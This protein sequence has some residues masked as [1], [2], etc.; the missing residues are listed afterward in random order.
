MDWI[1]FFTAAL[2][3]GIVV[4]F[5]DFL[6]SEFTSKRN[7]TA[8]AKNIVN[9]HIDPIL[10]SADQLLGHLISLSDKDF[11]TL[12][13]KN[14][15]ESQ[16]E[17]EYSIY[18]FSHFWACLLIL[19]KD[20]VHVDLTKRKEGRHLLRFVSTL[21][22][23]RNRLLSRVEQQVIGEAL[24]QE[25]SRGL[26]IKSF[27]HFLEEYNDKNTSFNTWFSPLESQL[28]HSRNRRIRQDILLYGVILHAMVDNL[29]AGHQY[30]RDR[31]SYP[32]KLSKKTRND[33]KNRIFG[34][35]LTGIKNHE[36]YW[37]A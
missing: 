12:S 8:S 3:G 31:K 29:D 4:K 6:Y 11:S 24:L 16:F 18:L 5:L 7:K 36:K 22:A 14:K 13:E 33:I 10:K 35:Y 21:N 37:N 23:K 26:E 1:Q 15:K 2:S 17:I 34:V 25:N 19:Q 20:C 9:K 32:N 30:I 28:I 27:Y